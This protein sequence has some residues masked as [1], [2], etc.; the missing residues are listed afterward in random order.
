M[1]PGGSRMNVHDLQLHI[2]PVL[3]LYYTDAAQTS[4]KRQVGI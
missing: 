2:F 1:L 3:N 4:H